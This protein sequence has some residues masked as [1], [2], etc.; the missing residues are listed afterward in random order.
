MKR[1]FLLFFAVSLCS[2]AVAQTTVSSL[3]ANRM[4]EPQGVADSKPLLSWIVE[5]AERGVKQTAY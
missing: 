4:S 5:S 1:L 3:R 2:L